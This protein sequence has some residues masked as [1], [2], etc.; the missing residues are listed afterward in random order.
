VT[1]DGFELKSVTKKYGETTALDGVSFTASRRESTAILGPSGCGKSTVL[2]L[3][4]GL[5]VPTNGRILLDD[6]VVSET[7]RVVTPP[8]RRGVSLVF[9][10]L[11]LWPNLSILDNVVLGLSGLRLSKKE[12]ETRARKTLTLC[13]IESLADRKPGGVS[14]GQEQRAALARALAPEPAF[15]LLD[16]PFSGLDLV[17]KKKLLEDIANLSSERKITTVLVTHDP[18]EARTLCGR[19]IVLRD[20]RLEELGSWSDL[21]ESPRS[22]ILRLFREHLGT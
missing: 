7:G 12:A 4:A 14:G 20:G 1:S 5:E 18:Q 22:D 15:L 10:D 17:T 13:S 19:A 6:K 3:L 8:H 9:Q 11:A 21:L 2:R 16:E